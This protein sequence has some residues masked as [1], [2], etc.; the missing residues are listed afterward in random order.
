MDEETRREGGDAGP[1]LGPMSVS[2]G[3][4]HRGAGGDDGAG[5]VGAHH[6]GVLGDPEA[7]VALGPVDGVQRDGVDGDEELGGAGGG[8]WAGGDG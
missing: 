1:W 4:C 3:G 8:G 5:D 2:A 6:R 7:V